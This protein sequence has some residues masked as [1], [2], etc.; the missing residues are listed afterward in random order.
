MT[1]SLYPHIL[2]TKG[3]K[4]VT[5]LDHQRGDLYRIDL[6]NW[7]QVEQYLDKDIGEDIRNDE[8]IQNLIQNDLLFEKSILDV[9]NSTF[10]KIA[11]HFYSF[12]EIS[13]I[14]IEI[15]EILWDLKS[16]VTHI[17]I[18][19]VQS[20]ELRF[21]RLTP[22]NDIIEIL[23]LFHDSS[24]R[25]IYLYM[26]YFKDIIY[27]L[28]SFEN[29]N[30]L[31]SIV[32]YNSPKEELL[33]IKFYVLYFSKSKSITNKHCGNIK[34]DYFMVSDIGYFESLHYNSCLN[35]K[36]SIDAKGNIKNCPS[37]LYL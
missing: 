4:F 28:D 21:L 30:R 12:S 9:N 35:R 6:G 8:I 37:T 5:L 22:L 11:N 16:V 34:S 18:L 29:I 19:N 15:D 27:C 1:L 3:N 14:I 32:V 25:S 20:C 26:P 10:T 17:N 33:D 36:L 31:T 23:N 13:N 2:V 7:S 24:L